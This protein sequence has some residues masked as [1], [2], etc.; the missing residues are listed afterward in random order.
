MPRNAA[1]A[2]LNG[3]SLPA[4]DPLVTSPVTSKS[5][6]PIIDLEIKP[7]PYKEVLPCL[8][9]CHD[10]VRTCPSALS[11][12]CPTGKYVNASYGHRASNGDITCSYLGAAYYLNDAFRILSPSVG[13]GLV[14]TGLWMMFWI[15]VQ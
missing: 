3:T 10:L 11:F 13:L 14:I 8:D 15:V 4:D 12:K 5:R 9:L 7:G 1:Q 2:F 6:N